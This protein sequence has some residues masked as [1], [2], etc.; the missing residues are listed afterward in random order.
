MRRVYTDKCGDKSVPE[1][2]SVSP[3]SIPERNTGK[4]LSAERYG[5]EIKGVGNASCKGLKALTR[6]LSPK[7]N[8]GCLER[9]AAMRRFYK[10]KCR[11]EKIARQ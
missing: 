8:P 9:A 10:A 11:H 6:S 4:C 1:P 3:P 5:P 7:N 2:A